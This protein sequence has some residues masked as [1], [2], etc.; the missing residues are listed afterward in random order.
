M[1]QASG[2]GCLDTNMFAADMHLCGVSLRYRCFDIA[3]QD[4]M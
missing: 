2:P 3:H 4:G 1:M